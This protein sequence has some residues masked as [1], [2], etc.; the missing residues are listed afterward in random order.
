MELRTALWMAQILNWDRDPLA[1]YAVHKGLNIER[2]E[3]RFMGTNVSDGSKEANEG[4]Q[5]RMHTQRLMGELLVEQGVLTEEQLKEALEIQ[6]NRSS[7]MSVLRDIPLVDL[8]DSVRRTLSSAEPRLL[9]EILIEKG[10]V[11]EDQ[12]KRALQEQKRQGEMTRH[13]K[14]EQMQT[15]L[16]FSTLIN[17]T[18]NL[19][20]LLTLIM[21]SANE[22]MT[23]EASTLMLLD[24]RTQE[25]VF[26][27]PT[28]PKREEFTEV[29]LPAGVGIAGW[30]AAHAE[31]LL[32][33]DTSKDSRFFK[34]FD[35]S[36]D[37]QS[38]SILC[39]PMRVKGKTL[40]VLEVINKK[41]GGAFERSDLYLLQTFANLASIAV[42]NARLYMEAIERHRLL[43]ELQVA[44]EI[45][46]RLLP[47]HPPSMESLDIGGVIK[48][49]SEVSGDFYDFIEVGEGKLAIMVGDVVGKG[50]PAAIL[51]AAA[52]SALRSQFEGQFSL[53]Q[54]MERVNRA[55][56]RDTAP[57][58]FVTLFCGLFDPQDGSFAYTNCGHNPALL[59]RGGDE[60]FQELSEGGTV[61]GA[62]QD[63]AYKEDRARLREGDLVV[64]YTDGITE[65]RNPTGEQ[66]G[67]DR[68][69]HC[70]RD[71]GNSS[72]REIIAS[73]LE[74]IEAFSE[75]TP[76]KDD[77]TLVV[78]R[79]TNG[80][81]SRPTN[82][83]LAEAPPRDGRG[84]IR[85]Q[86]D[87]S[88]NQFLSPSLFS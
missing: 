16:D 17:S 59:L 67:R 82:P 2:I 15:L 31:P 24:D 49:A 84:G 9:G 36:F 85:S 21:E 74:S 3:D 61:L 40:G 58:S 73:I 51:M 53:S 38:K 10:F 62:F 26:S 23:A 33:A 34:E 66:F 42:E 30:V 35:E 52:R 29:R 64:L 87:H 7:D 79:V 54:V 86:V 69:L 43:G 76:R 60:R 70:L 11:Q 14:L 1:I 55:L 13:L 39:V 6:R 88:T 57:G 45:Q 71:R 32:V 46:S 19:V 8:I 4:S 37:F 48:P 27:I 41:D 28:G 81:F 65:A 72:A 56:F 63:L 25:L 75:G 80:A 18:I 20:D 77:Q 68:L 5:Q 47:E 22:V 50:I 44:Q 12:I 83:R 78:L